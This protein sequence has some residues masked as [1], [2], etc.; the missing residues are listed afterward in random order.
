MSHAN[1]IISAPISLH[2]DVYPVLGLAKTGTYYDVAYACG[3][4]H[5][6]INKWSKHKPVRY[7]SPSELTNAQW[8]SA[9]YGMGVTYSSNIDTV[10]ESALYGDWEYLPP[11]PGTD[12]C[13]LTDFIGYNHNC[14]RP[15]TN[16]LMNQQMEADQSES[17]SINFLETTDEAANIQGNINLREIV[18]NGQSFGNCYFGIVVIDTNK[19]KVYGIT[20][21]ST[22]GNNA[23]RIIAGGAGTGYWKRGDYTVI[24]LISSVKR[25]F[26]LFS[27]GESWSGG[28]YATLPTRPGTLTVRAWDD[29]DFRCEA[30]WVY[31]SQNKR[32]AINYDL[33]YTNRTSQPVNIRAVTIKCGYYDRRVEYD[34][35]KVYLWNS[36]VDS[37][38][39]IVIPANV[40]DADPRLGGS[41][42][43][44][45]IGEPFN[46][47]DYFI[48]LTFE[49]N[50]V[51]DWA[52]DVKD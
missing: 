5:G 31:D 32:S 51:E 36:Q 29:I 46:D 11:R 20:S 47:E 14:V 45:M 21:E 30:E 15:C 39:D 43:E 35:V 24:P 22:F 50:Y 33:Y 38:R 12:W 25:D 18:V 19:N 16:T 49:T 1:G 34:P 44:Q 48:E 17:V 9:L 8:E 10:I 40:E 42:D 28:W 26:C 37:G 4:E 13:R 6:K 41:I 3:N 7:D 27:N 2:A 52:Y 23:V